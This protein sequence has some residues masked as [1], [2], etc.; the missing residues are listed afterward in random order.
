MFIS[1]CEST[2]HVEIKIAR[3]CRNNFVNDSTDEASDSVGVSRVEQTQRHELFGN[4]LLMGFF[5]EN[6]C[7][8]V[9]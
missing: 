2:Q 9:A 3:H 5:P 7:D 1:C 8:D 6:P 4:E